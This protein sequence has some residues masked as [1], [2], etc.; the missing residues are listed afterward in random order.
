M[1]GDH[2]GV[3]GDLRYFHTFQDLEV[4]GFTLSNSTLDY[5]RASAGV[6]VTF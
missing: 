4:L 1:A 6:V 2:I 3:R 5:G